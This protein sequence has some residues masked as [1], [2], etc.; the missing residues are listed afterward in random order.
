MSDLETDEL[1]KVIPPQKRL[2]V[3]VHTCNS[4]IQNNHESWPAW[5][6]KPRTE[7]VAQWES[8]SPRAVLPKVHKVFSS[9]LSISD[10]DGRDPTFLLCL[11]SQAQR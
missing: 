11:D 4:S 6:P 9:I 8:N 7:Y 2:G 5:D 3:V 10:S 1:E